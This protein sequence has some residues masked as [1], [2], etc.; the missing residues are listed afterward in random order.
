MRYLRKRR[1]G[2][3][4]DTAAEAALREFIIPGERTSSEKVRDRKW[5]LRS[6]CTVNGFGEIIA[7]ALICCASAARQNNQYQTKRIIKVRVPP[8]QYPDFYNGPKG[9]LRP[10]GSPIRFKEFHNKHPEFARP[11]HPPQFF[12]NYNNIYFKHQS[13]PPPLPQGLPGPSFSGAG[14]GQSFKGF[15][16]EIHQKFPLTY[17]E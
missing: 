12:N 7:L 17:G 16:K 5:L 4:C 13:R 14:F 10:S 1:R 15:S 9:Y 8:R 6:D 2:G 3:G 11:N